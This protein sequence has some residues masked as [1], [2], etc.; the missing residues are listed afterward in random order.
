MRSVFIE[1][2][3]LQN[4]SPSCLNR[5]DTNAPK[6]CIF[7]GVRRA[8]ISSQCLKRSVRRHSSFQE[9]LHDS[10]GTRTKDLLKLVGGRLRET[11]GADCPEDLQAPLEELV[12]AVGLKLEEG[13]AQYLLL[14]GH[15]TIANLASIAREHWEHLVAAAS[16]APVAPPPSTEEPQG[17]KKPAARRAAKQASSGLDPDVRERFRSAFRRG[18]RAVDLALF[19]RMVA[20]I[21]EM[22]VDGACQVAH[23][24]STNEV[25]M[26]MDFYTAVDDLQP[27]G[28]TGAGMMGMVE[29]NSACFY[30]YSL[31]D[32]GKLLSNLG[33]DDE[34]ARRTVAAYIEASVRAI[35]TGK[36]NSMAAHNPPS[37]VYVCVREGMPRSLADAFV[38]PVRPRPRDLVAGSIEALT[39]YRDRLNVAYGEDPNTTEVVFAVDAD[40]E[41]NG[42][43]SARVRG[44][45]EL[46]AKVESCLS[47]AEAVQT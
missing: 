16:Q 37:L 20:D 21:P 8:R 27:L 46:V 12:R 41:L 39:L 31:I 13:R 17:R 30:R 10:L 35:P 38:K 7:G 1:L 29:F 33:G 25:Q 4:F 23:A 11:W 22:T 5:D 24:L 28:E 40:V 42:L 26:E 2:H 44:L 45:A 36:Q 34:L 15:D 9:R 43:E 32:W 47:G 18:S 14:L 3:I 6:D 19:G